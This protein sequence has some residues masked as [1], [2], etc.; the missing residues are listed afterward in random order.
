MREKYLR[1][2]D[3][4]YHIR[5][6]WNS[7]LS[8]LD[9]TQAHVPYWS[10]GFKDGNLT[11]FH[12]SGAWDRCHDVARELHGLT[13]AEQV[14]GERTPKSI[15]DDLSKHLLALFD[16]ADGL[17]GTLADKTGLRFIHLHN[18]RETTHGLTALIQRGDGRAEYWAKRM[19]RRM[20]QALDDKGQI[21]LDR[22]PKYV[23]EYNYQP[24][25]EGRAVDALVRYYRVTTDPVALELAGLLASYAL[26]HC[27]TAV[28]A[29]TQAAGNHGHSINAL[30]A[31]MADLALLRNDGSLL[32]RVKAAYD[33]GLPRFN[34]TFGWSMESLNKFTAR[35]ESNNT[36]DLLRASLLLGRAGF[37]EYFEVAERI[38]R[39]HLLSSQITDVRG[40]SDDPNQKEDRLRNLASRIRGGF[41]FPTPNDL[42]ARPDASPY[43]CDITSGAL[44][45]LCEV[46]KAIVTEDAA[47]LRINLLLDH[48]T[49]NLRVKS[50]L[51]GDGR[52]DIESDRGRNLLV[53]IPPWVSP[54]TLR[55]TLNGVEH[56]LAFIGRYLLVPAKE[57]RQIVRITFPMPETRTV[58]SIAFERYTIDWRGNQIVAMS[59]PANY[60]PMF[61]PCS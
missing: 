28:G 6:A 13:M 5:L 41:G 19:V 36:G 9:P 51:S 44:D 7:L 52:I 48:E 42:L 12:H 31:G 16:E 38:L 29:L 50:Y 56:P 24:S 34:S 55:L 30:V 35:G 60:W 1:P 10:C 43:V 4:L 27:F 21:H 53:R 3:L 40:L 23:E 46:A 33:V 47:G 39:S 2:I 58:E 49:K 20:R 14:I 26:E 25:Q 45:A 59:P 17:P 8:G 57:A 15:V 61:P 32:N 37:P 11:G 22:L 54:A 18:I